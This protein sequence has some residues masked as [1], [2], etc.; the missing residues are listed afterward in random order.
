MPS[1]HEDAERKQHVRLNY[2]AIG[3]DVQKVY[4]DGCGDDLRSNASNLCTPS[5]PSISKHL[6]PRAEIRRENFNDAEIY[7]RKIFIASLACFR[8]S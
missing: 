6:A 2:A 8:S 4:C 3:I 5:E 7:R 1:E